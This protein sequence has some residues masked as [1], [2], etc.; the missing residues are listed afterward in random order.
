MAGAEFTLYNAKGDIVPKVTSDDE[1]KVV[2]SDL[3][4]GEYNVV[5]T[6]AP[7]EY[8]ADSTTI[9]FLIVENGRTL[10]HT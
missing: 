5:E 2:F 9:P 10:S 6:K 8:E 1:G 7:A 4:Y 3:P